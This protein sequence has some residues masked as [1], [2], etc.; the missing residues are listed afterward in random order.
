MGYFKKVEFFDQSEP[1]NESYTQGKSDITLHFGIKKCFRAVVFA[2]TNF[3]KKVSYAEKL[4]IR[5][6]G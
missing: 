1:Q 4:E 6:K 2:G 3:E 5:K